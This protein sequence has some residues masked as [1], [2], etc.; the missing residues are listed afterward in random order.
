MH[1]NRTTPLRARQYSCHEAGDRTPRSAASSSPPASPNHP[2]VPLASDTQLRFSTNIFPGCLDRI[3]ARPCPAPTGRQPLS[4]FCECRTHLH[5]SNRCATVSR[6]YGPTP[7]SIFC[8]Y[9]LYLHV[10]YR[11]ARMVEQVDT[12]DLK[13]RGQRCPCGFDPRSGYKTRN[14]PA[15]IQRVY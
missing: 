2:N 12:R 6:P 4:I 3:A 14:K 11:N 5:R 8:E 1:R 15:E 13:S 9:F 10:F 7:L